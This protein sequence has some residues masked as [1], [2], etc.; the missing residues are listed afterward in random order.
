MARLDH[1]EEERRDLL[2]R[3]SLLRIPERLVVCEER[4]MRF[5][6]LADDL[7]SILLERA[8]GLGEVDDD[9]HQVRHLCLRCAVGGKEPDGNPDLFKEP[10]C[11]PG[12]LSRHPAPWPDSRDVV[13]RFIAVDRDH[14]P[15]VPVAG[16]AVGEVRDLGDVRAA[17]LHPVKP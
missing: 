2:D 1:A 9:V 8:A 16:L 11:D 10:L 14:D 5:H 7:E 6:D 15:H 17:L 13:D 12:I 4:C 3:L